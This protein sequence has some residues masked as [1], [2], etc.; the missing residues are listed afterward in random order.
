MTVKIIYTKRHKITITRNA[1]GEVV[2]VTLEP[3]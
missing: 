2:S 1:K 3:S